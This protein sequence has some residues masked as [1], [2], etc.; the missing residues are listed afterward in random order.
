MARPAL[1]CFDG[2][3]HATDAIRGA[4]ALLPGQEALVL[5][6]ATPAKDELPFDPV[7]DVVG[8]LSGLYRDWDEAVAEIADRQARRGCELAAE[9]G[10]HPRS[11]AAFGKPAATILRV[12]DEHDAAVI[13]LGAG[14]YKT[15]G[16]VL[17]SVVARVLHEANRPVLVI[18]PRRNSR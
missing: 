15:L 14:N 7:S 3:E 1:L 2:S 10:L 17:G 6:V 13:V 9:A 4:G 11:L 8:R 5:C 16:G 12:A 18:P